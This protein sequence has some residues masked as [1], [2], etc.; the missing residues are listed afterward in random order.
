MSPPGEVGTH[1][2]MSTID[3]S[4]PDMPGADNLTPA[5]AETLTLLAAQK[6]AYLAAYP[7]SGDALWIAQE[8]ATADAFDALAA[9]LRDPAERADID[10]RLAT[11]GETMPRP[12]PDASSSWKEVMHTAREPADLLAVDAGLERLDLARQANVLNMALD[13]AESIGARDAVQKMLAHQMAGAHRLAMRLVTTAN[14]DIYRHERGRTMG[15]SPS[16]LAEATRS[17]GAAARLMDAFSRSAI[18]L[19]RLRN[20]GRQ[21]VT[22]Q[23]VTVT[24][25]GQAVVAGSVTPGGNVAAQPPHTGGQAG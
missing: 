21:T 22:V 13:T 16:A 20:G 3:K 19:D 1:D 2:A 18:A 12:H 9:R 8:H 5:D 25:G 7:V 4:V 15:S 10:A 6:R 11:G 24:D 17:A 23:H 14:A